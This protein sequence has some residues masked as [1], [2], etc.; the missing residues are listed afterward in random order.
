MDYILFF[1]MAYIFPF[2]GASGKIIHL[3]EILLGKRDSMI[4]RCER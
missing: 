4:S 3:G 2:L 1:T